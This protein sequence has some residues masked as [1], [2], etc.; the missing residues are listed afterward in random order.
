[1]ALVFDYSVQLPPCDI[2][3]AELLRLEQE[4]GAGEALRSVKIAL[5]GAASVIDE[6][7]EDTAADAFLKMSEH[8]AQSIDE[9]RKKLKTQTET[10]RRVMFR[11]CLE[12]AKVL[13]GGNDS[14]S[15]V[16]VDNREL[17]EEDFVLALG[18]AESLL[19]DIQY[20][21]EAITRH[22]AED[23]ANASL[24]V[25]QMM[26]IFMQS[27]VNSITPEQIVHGTLSS[28]SGSGSSLDIEIIEEDGTVTTV[29][30]SETKYAPRLRLLWPS[31]RD[32][33][34]RT[35]SSISTVALQRPII[36][37]V[38]AICLW[39]TAV[40]VS[41]F[42]MPI[43]GGDIVLQRMYNSFQN[44]SIVS[45]LE[46]SAASS[47]QV[48]RLNYLCSKV[49]ARQMWRVGKRQL[50][51][52]GGAVAIAKDL[53][54]SVANKISHPVE[55][56]EQVVYGSQIMASGTISFFQTIYQGIKTPE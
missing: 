4:K 27:I 48:L 10:E 28:K 46:R 20:S 44:T 56:I 5:D 22:E 1:M 38:L 51:R 16:K 42:A 32:Q 6:L 11:E 40:G 43:I 37:S 25:A 24:A 21:F 14:H 50:R 53:G 36:S 47:V 52:R 9:L 23:I 13:S 17:I 54:Y 31:L 30:N 2:Q 29:E 33:A 35:I 41:I 18:A 45:N 34:S 12:D 26:I 49:M 3:S 15:L 7:D 19:E 39:P 8:I 55:T